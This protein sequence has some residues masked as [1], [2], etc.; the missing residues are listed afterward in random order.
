MPLI[1]ETKYDM[2][3]DLTFCD[4]LLT[5]ITEILMKNHIVTDDIH[6]I[7]NL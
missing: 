4:K 7:V 6:N 5:W 3:C 2:S 1:E